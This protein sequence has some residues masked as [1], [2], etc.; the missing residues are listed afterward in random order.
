MTVIQ[1]QLSM[2]ELMN[3][4]ERLLNHDEMPPERVVLFIATL[5]GGN[6]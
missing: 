5:Y 1:I 3:W 6:V 4:R 2:K